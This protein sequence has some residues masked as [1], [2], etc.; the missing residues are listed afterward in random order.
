[1]RAAAIS[2]VSP[3]RWRALRVGAGANQRLQH[4]RGAVA[5]GLQQR[6]HAVAIGGVDRRAG[7]EQRPRHVEIGVIGRPEQRRRA[8]GA[9]LVHVHALGDERCDRGEVA[10]L[11]GD[12]ERSC[13]LRPGRG[14]RGEPVTSGS[15]ESS[16]LEERA[17]RILGPPSR[18]GSSNRL[19]RSRATG[20][21]TRA[22]QDGS[23]TPAV[24]DVR[25]P[26]PRGRV[27]IVRILAF[28]RAFA[29]P[30]NGSNF[31]QICPSRRSGELESWLLPD[32]R[33]KPG[34]AVMG[35]SGR[36]G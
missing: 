24:Q 35:R 28:R 19:V 6:R 13:R 18:G 23:R 20:D 10:V 9:W 14:R 31:A 2:G 3:S 25:P 29:Q 1:M 7:R 15:S 5:A 36:R 17:V 22:V 11:G 12:D 21:L 34:C 8:V 30:E 32:F 27:E 33:G 16:H 26:A 4:R